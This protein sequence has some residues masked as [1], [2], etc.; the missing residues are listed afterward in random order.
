M[1]LG[2]WGMGLGGLGFGGLDM[3][4][5]LGSKNWSNIRVSVPTHQT[6]PD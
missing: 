1:G 5:V 2:V 3:I 4:Q 6:T